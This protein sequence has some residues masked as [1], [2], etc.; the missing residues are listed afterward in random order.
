MRI[1]ILDPAEEPRTP[2]LIAA[3]FAYIIT[4]AWLWLSSFVNRT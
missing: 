1:P 3:N 4:A 2:L